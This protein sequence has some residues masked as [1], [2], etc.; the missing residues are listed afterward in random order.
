MAKK[1]S[2]KPSASPWDRGDQSE[3]EYF[4]ALRIKIRE[5]MASLADSG[6]MVHIISRDDRWAVVKE[7]ARRATKIHETKSSA[8]DHGR[9]IARKS[10]ARL[11]IHKRDGSVEKT[12]NMAV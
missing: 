9:S 2:K 11:V 12:E 4:D 10:G 3:Q 8:V 5:T 7:K 6:G 1:I